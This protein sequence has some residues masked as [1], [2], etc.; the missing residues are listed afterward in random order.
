MNVAG[1]SALVTGGAS[2]LGAA[3]A[4]RLAGKGARVL[5][6]D[7]QN[8]LGEAM[9]DEV[10]GGFVHTDVTDTAQVQTAVSAAA[11]MGP[12]R[13]VVNCAGIGP[14]GRTLN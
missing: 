9:A 13:I 12:L 2:G 1:V 7:L 14:P 6:A 4:R 11:E 8:D 3:T 5:I 10:D